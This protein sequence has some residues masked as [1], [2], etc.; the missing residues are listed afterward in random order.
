MDWPKRR[1]SPSAPKPVADRAA[2]PGRT[3]QPVAQPDHVRVHPLERCPCVRPPH[4]LPRIAA[5]DAYFTVSP[6][7]AKPLQKFS[8]TKILVRADAKSTLLRQIV[9]LGFNEVSLFPGLD[10]LARDLRRKAADQNSDHS[11]SLEAGPD[12]SA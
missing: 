3:L 4:I 6:N 7:A 9:A 1:P 5:Q 8:P 11:T 10:G 2:N 12:S